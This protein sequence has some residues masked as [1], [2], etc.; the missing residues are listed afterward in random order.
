MLSEF[1]TLLALANG[2]V[3]YANMTTSPEK[4]TAYTLINARGTYEAQGESV[5]FT[6]MNANISSLLSGSAIYDVV[7]PA[8]ED[9]NTASGTADIISHVNSIIASNAN[10]CIVLQGYS[11]GATATVDAMINM[12]SG[13][14]FDA[15]K[16]V[17]LIGNP[18]RKAGL[19]CN[20]DNLGYTSTKNSSGA[21]NL[22]GQAPIPSQWYSKTLDVCRSL[23]GIC[24]STHALGVN[25]VHQSYGTDRNTQSLGLSYMMQVL[26]GVEF[27]YP[28]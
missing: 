6:T 15:V 10:A 11:Q 12:T 1:T 24:D 18:R 21:L 8:A 4:C 9:Q 22:L 27:V 25:A 28:S 20:V 3:Q 2:W 7:Y 19:P 23:D 14:G 5:G 16:G 17:F 26:T 13:A